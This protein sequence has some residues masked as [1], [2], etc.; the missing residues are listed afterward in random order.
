MPRSDLSTLMDFI[1]FN[2]CACF[3]LSCFVIFVLVFLFA[4]L[5]YFSTLGL[6]VLREMEG[7]VGE[8]E[9]EREERACEEGKK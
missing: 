8:K 7:R 9:K 3:V 5:F 6:M 4:W 1:F 2:V